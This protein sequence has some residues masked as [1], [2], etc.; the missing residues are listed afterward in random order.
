M[1]AI[2]NNVSNS[3]I[4]NYIERVTE[5]S[6]SSQH[7]PTTE[8]L[9]KI[10]SELG[11]EPEEIQAAQKQSHDHYIRAQ[12]YMKLRHWDDAIAELQDAVVF[13]PSNLDM[14]ISLAHAYMGRWQE[15]HHLQD[16]QSIRFRIRQCLDIKP[17]CQEALN[18][19]AKLSN[20]LKLRQRIF[21]TLVLGLSGVVIGVGSFLW[22]SDA[23]PNFFN[24]QSKIEQ[25]EQQFLAEIY[26]LQQQQEAV[27]AEILTL[28]QSN[29][30]QYQQNLSLLKN[31]I[32]QLEKKLTIL[33]QKIVDLEKSQPSKLTPKPSNQD[34]E[35]NKQIIDSMIIR[36]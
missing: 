3:V 28:Q 30:Q 33:Q 19:L 27:K 5:L 10:A 8:E 29:N 6:Q 15:K 7:I 36:R 25:L 18:L 22:L 17:D 16:E 11:I 34:M 12:G 4:N 14:L 2:S 24:R 32:N 1:T 31:R 35:N 13:N 20:S 26:Q 21:I 23:F 9:E